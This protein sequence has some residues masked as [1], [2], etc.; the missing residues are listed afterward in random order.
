MK[1]LVVGLAIVAGLSVA[2]L[3][4][5]VAIAYYFGPRLKTGFRFI[6]PGG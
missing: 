1:R 4:T 6:T 3:F 2:A 5:I